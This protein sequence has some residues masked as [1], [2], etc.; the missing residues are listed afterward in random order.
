MIGLGTGSNRWLLLPAKT[1]GT[2]N[3]IPS[4][5]SSNTRS[6]E[7]RGHGHAA[8][9]VSTFLNSNSEQCLVRRLSAISVD[10]N[11]NYRKFSKSLPET[12]QSF[13]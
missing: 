8:G 2:R 10:P 11:L 3:P 13:D 4:E 12:V 5:L 7:V 6:S 9:N 1:L